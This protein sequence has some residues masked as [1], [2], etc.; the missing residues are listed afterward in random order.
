MEREE[1]MHI[2]NR[3][4]NAKLDYVVQMFDRALSG[5][6]LKV[7]NEF[8]DKII[9]FQGL[10]YLDKL[11]LRYHVENRLFAMSYDLVYEASIGAEEEEGFVFA[12]EL[13]G[14]ASIAGAEFKDKG[15]MQDNP[16][17]EAFLRRLN[18]KL[19]VDRIKDLH[20]TDIKVTYTVSSATWK[21]VCRCLIGSSTWNFI[22]P[23]FQLI[24]PK[25]EEC[26]KTIEFFELVMDALVNKND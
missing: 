23:V 13:K 2:L 10:R 5:K 4:A 22:P 26:I 6:F 14:I 19:I 15:K 7:K 20:L 11:R 12:A 17:A 9:L 16:E 24:T 21:I 18:N 1:S 8:L 3:K 25:K